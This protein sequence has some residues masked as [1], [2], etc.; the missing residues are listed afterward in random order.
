MTVSKVENKGKNIEELQKI[1][2][3]FYK[4]VKK[5]AKNYFLAPFFY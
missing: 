3:I 1:K 2:S 5:G 4:K